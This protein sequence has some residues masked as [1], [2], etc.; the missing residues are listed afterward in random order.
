MEYHKIYNIRKGPYNKSCT[1][2]IPSTAPVTNAVPV[3]PSSPAETHK[4][5]KNIVLVPYTLKLN[6]WGGWQVKDPQFA[7][8][9]AAS[10]NSIPNEQ[11]EEEQVGLVYQP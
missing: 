2:P 1:F 8:S 11:E 6:E 4:T 7:S 10:S 5:I 9:T 3:S